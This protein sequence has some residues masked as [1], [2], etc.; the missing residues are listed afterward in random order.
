M[1]NFCN[2]PYLTSVLDKQGTNIAGIL[3]LNRGGEHVCDQKI[4]E[5]KKKDGM[6]EHSVKGLLHSYGDRNGMS[7]L[8]TF[9][10]M[11]HAAKKTSAAYILK[12][13]TVCDYSQATGVEFKDK[14]KS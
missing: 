11:E 6:S 14:L 12:C 9:R 3:M 8:P 13:K 1:D 5:T 2:S 7:I 4:R 10:N